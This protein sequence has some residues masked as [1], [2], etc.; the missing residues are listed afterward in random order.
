MR[1]LLHMAGALILAA[2][3][4]QALPDFVWLNSATNRIT[5]ASGG[6][7]Y[8]YGVSNN[9]AVSCFLQLVYAGPNKTNDPA[10]AGG[11][12]VSGDDVVV[13]RA[14]IGNNNA[15]APGYFAQRTFAND[16]AGC[17]FVRAWSAPSENFDAGLAPTALTNYYGDSRI[18][19]NLLIEP[20]SLMPLFNFGGPSG[21]A[22]D[23][24]PGVYDSDGDGL[25]D[26]WEQKYFG[27]P[28]GAVSS[29][30]G[31]GDDVPNGE[32][33]AAGT[34]PT[35]SFSYFHLTLV[36]AQAAGSSNRVAIQ[37]TSEYGKLYEIQR[38]TNLLAG[39]ETILSNHFGWPALTGLTN[40]FPG[41][42]PAFYRVKVR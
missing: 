34:N 37:W 22:T 11:A 40:V 30:D 32:E 1:K 18:Y 15:G 42:T 17:Y 26:W 6:T 19:T 41:H 14:W 4:A 25:P 9:P 28:T 33:F 29:A 8:L 2:T 36:S 23:Q 21:F 10:V 7:N 16:L 39:F 38:S 13:D 35:N 3:C 20:P 31:D 24:M 12:G 27:S 5:Y